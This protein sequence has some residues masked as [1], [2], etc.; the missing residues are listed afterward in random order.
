MKN[1]SILLCLPPVRASHPGPRTH[2]NRQ[3]LLKKSAMLLGLMTG[4]CVYSQT[5]TASV[6]GSIGKCQVWGYPYT[7]YNTAGAS[8]IVNDGITVTVD[9]DR[10]IGAVNL[11]GSGAMSL[12]GAN[13]ITLSG[14]GGEINCRWDIPAGGSYTIVNND[15]NPNTAIDRNIGT[16]FTAPYNGNYGWIR[17]TGWSAS[18]SGAFLNGSINLRRNSDGT[19]SS[20]YYR[21]EAGSCG[22]LAPPAQAENWDNT[23]GPIPLTAGVGISYTIGTGYADSSGCTNT[24]LNATRGSAIVVYMN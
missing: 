19:S 16:F 9:Q 20:I 5:N 3:G 21:N 18:L 13:G 1:I 14:S 22:L 24:T 12:S 11:A 10:N 7:L 8:Q 17:N 4:L 6:S 23:L 15:G 2:R